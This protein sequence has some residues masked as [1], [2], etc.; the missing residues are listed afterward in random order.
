M[1]CTSC[2]IFNPSIER[3][4][5]KSSCG[6][7]Q[8]ESSSQSRSESQSAPSCGGA[9]SQLQGAELSSVWAHVPL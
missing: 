5:D 2:A 3:Q 6:I 9:V 8:S 1:D 7:A 4:P